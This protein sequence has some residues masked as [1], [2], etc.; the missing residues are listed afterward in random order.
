MPREL[1]LPVARPQRIFI[2]G[3]SGSGKSTLARRIAGVLDISAT[4]LDLIYRDGGGNG[5]PRVPAVRD[6][7]LAR[8]AAEDAWIVEGIH[9]DGTAGLMDRPT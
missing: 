5:P 7:D 3:Q 4:D 9:L 8:I 6:A 1:R 2:I